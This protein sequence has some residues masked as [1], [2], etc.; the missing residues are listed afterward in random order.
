M[1]L[2]V[3][4]VFSEDNCNHGDGREKITP[5]I[6]LPRNIHLLHRNIPLPKG[7]HL[8]LEEAEVSPGEEIIIKECQ[9]GGGGGE[10]VV[11]PSQG[12]KLL[13]RDQI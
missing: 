5:I 10:G 7:S 4:D 11:S 12:R 3:G 8:Q 2:V 13:K 1:P 6:S 9:I